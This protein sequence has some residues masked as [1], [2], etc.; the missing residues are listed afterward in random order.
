MWREELAPLSSG[1][2][3]FLLRIFQGLPFPFYGLF[4]ISVG[5]IG[6]NILL[7]WK[8]FRDP[9]SL[10]GFSFVVMV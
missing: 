4:L 1:H 8:D 7:R 2:L 9:S 6:K 3:F 5:C 10:S